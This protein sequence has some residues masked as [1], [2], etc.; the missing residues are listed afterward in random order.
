VA[1]RPGDIDD[2]ARNDLSE[3]AVLG[4]AEPQT[5]GRKPASSGGGGGGGGGGERRKSRLPKAGKWWVLVIVGVLILLALGPA[6]VSG[7]KKTPRDRVGISYGGGPF[8]GTHYQR[9]VQPGSSL[10]FN[11]FYDPLYLYPADQVNYIISSQK[12]VGAQKSADS[13]VAPTADRIQVTYQVATYFKLNIDRLREFH[14]QF[15]LRYQAYTTNGWNNLIRDTFRQQIENALQEE[16][17][18]VQVAQLFGDADKLVQLQDSIQAKLTQRLQDAMGARFF[19]APTYHQ[20]GKCGDPTFVIKKVDIPASVATAFQQNKTS[21]IAILTKQNEIK[22]RQ[23]EAQSIAALGLS[24]AEYNTLK[25][26][27]S[28]KINFWVLPNDSGVVLNTPN[29][30]GGTTSNTKANSG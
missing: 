26:I 14:E 5:V 16:T 30:G 29:T 18:R 6:F 1:D 21:A 2:A 19:C 3:P 11:G 22:Q 20:G 17:R 24:G 8:E 10:F 13:V 15:G 12:G 25:A 9:I 4:A 7:L 28:G 23:A 27:E